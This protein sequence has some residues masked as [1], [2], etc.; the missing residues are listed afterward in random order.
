MLTIIHFP[1]KL[2]CAGSNTLK[3]YI[4]T[5]FQQLTVPPSELLPVLLVKIS[6]LSPLSGLLNVM[7][8]P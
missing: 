6:W 3:L 1:L 7:P 8:D 4:H 2:F 5:S